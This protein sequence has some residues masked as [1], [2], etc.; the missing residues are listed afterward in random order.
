MPSDQQRRFRRQLRLVLR[1]LHRAAALNPQPGDKESGTSGRSAFRDAID[2]WT[3]VLGLIE[4]SPTNFDTSWLVLVTR[5]ESFLD[6]H[7]AKPA[8]G[9]EA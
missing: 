3:A 9:G 5:A 1:A 8:E 4:Q 6:H 7:G 2:L